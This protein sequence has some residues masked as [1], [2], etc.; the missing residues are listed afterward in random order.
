MDATET[1]EF[2]LADAMRDNRAEPQPEA[3]Y[4]RRRRISGAQTGEPAQS[5]GV[6]P[7]SKRNASR[8][9]DKG[10]VIQIDG[11]SASQVKEEDRTKATGILQEIGQRFADNRARGKS[12]AYEQYQKDLAQNAQ[13]L[14]LGGLAS[15]KEL[16]DIFMKIEDF[17]KQSSEHGKTPSTILAEWLRGDDTAEVESLNSLLTV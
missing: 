8:R 16:T 11:K 1:P 6:R 2:G 3:P 14:V 9:E 15:V 4:R 7:N 5:S 10:L 13:Y 12:N 17:R